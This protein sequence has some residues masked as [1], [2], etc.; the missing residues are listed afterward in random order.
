V[1]I[2]AVALSTLG[3]LV[4]L[5]VPVDAYR[6]NLGT[7]FPTPAAFF[8]IG[9]AFALI[10]VAGG[11]L[12]WHGRRLGPWLLVLGTIG[13]LMAWPWLSAAIIYLVATAIGVLSLRIA[14]RPT[15]TTGKFARLGS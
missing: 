5:Y 12:T 4:S 6:N 7:G 15:G 2:A 9:A 3:A 10:G 11:L 8:V 1:R 14:P 13:G